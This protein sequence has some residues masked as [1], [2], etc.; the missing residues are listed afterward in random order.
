LGG[1]LVLSDNKISKD[2]DG[3]DDHDND[4]NNKLLITHRITYQE[5]EEV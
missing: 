2:D 1:L 4:V 3:D 5:S